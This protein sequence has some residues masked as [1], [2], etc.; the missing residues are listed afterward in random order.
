MQTFVLLIPLKW[1]LGAETS[2]NFYVTYDCS[3]LCAPVASVVTCQNNA[4]ST[5]CQ[6]IISHSTATEVKTEER[7]TT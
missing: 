5:Y 1:L 6:I 3:L 4:R 2:R 7:T